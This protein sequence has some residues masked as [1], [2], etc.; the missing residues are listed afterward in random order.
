MAENGST[1]RIGGIEAAIAASDW[2]AARRAMAL[3]LAKMMDET[4]SA[5]DVKGITMSLLPLM[6][7]CEADEAA[8]GASSTPYDAIMREAEAALANA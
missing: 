8:Q 2:P 3:R 5:R 6:E 4:T 1:M 7:R